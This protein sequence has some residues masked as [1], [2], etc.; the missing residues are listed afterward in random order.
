[1]ATAIVAERG[2]PRSGG[3]TTMPITPLAARLSSTGT[4]AHLWAALTPPRGNRVFHG[5]GSR[6]CSMT[7]PAFAGDLRLLGARSS[8]GHP[9]RD[10][11][12]RQEI[13]ATG[14]F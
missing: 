3:Y 4:T 14:P 6:C 7:H 13:R 11:R 9:H 12:C 10:K 2:T 1:M 5:R 8:E